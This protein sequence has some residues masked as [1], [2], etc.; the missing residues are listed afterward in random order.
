VE[1]E[2]R[3]EQLTVGEEFAQNLS[4]IQRTGEW[5]TELLR[6]VLSL[7]SA[8]W[9]CLVSDDDPA[10]SW[11]LSSS[12]FLVLCSLQVPRL[13][14]GHRKK[15]GTGYHL[16]RNQGILWGG[17]NLCERERE[18]CLRRRPEG[19]SSALE[20]DFDEEAGGGEATHLFPRSRGLLAKK[21]P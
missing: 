10:R 13:N 20:V 18:R 19:S 3:V 14:T 2:E 12:F 11:V 21:S 9:R 6:P 5:I 4:E 17:P 8:F 16:G 1:S 15:T 7:S